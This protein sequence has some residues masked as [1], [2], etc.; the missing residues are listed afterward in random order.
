[1]TAHVD[2]APTFFKIAGITPRSDFDG[3]AIPLNED[4]ISEAY[5]SRQEHVN[6]EYWGK[7]A[8]EGNYGLS[9]DDDGKLVGFQYNNTYKGLR[10]VGHDYSLYYS[11]W[12]SNE[13]ELYDLTRDPYQTENI[14]PG[15]TSIDTLE[16]RIL[17][18]P[19]EN[20]IVRLDAMLFVTKSCKGAS[21][22]EPWNALHP[23]GSVHTLR[24]A[25]DTRFDEFYGEIQQKV[26][27]DRCEEGYILD[28]EGPQNLSL[29]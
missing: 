24:D 23:S 20:V 10:L 16:Y 6:V 1:V 5:H 7:A 25:L 18:R 27:F 29:L 14:Y 26:R 2:L 17:S 4:E 28:A 22:I 9:L 8:P 13:H 21:C 12:C 11:V 15:E 19:L 3:T